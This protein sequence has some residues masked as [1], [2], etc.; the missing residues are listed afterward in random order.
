M[1]IGKGCLFIRQ[2]FQFGIIHIRPA[3]EFRLFLFRTEHSVKDRDNT[4]HLF[5]D[6]RV[7]RDQ[8]NGF[9]LFLVQTDQEFHDFFARL[10]VQVSRRFI[11]HN[12]F[13]II[14]K[15]TG[16]RHTLLLTAGHFFRFMIDTGTQPH[17]LQRID[18]ALF[19]IGLV[20]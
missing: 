3:L 20:F 7:M 9:P 5:P 12:D 15:C 19:G 18:C 10:A 11:S 2:P 17:Q 6:F 1:V 8:N 14:D 13:R 4:W 16:N